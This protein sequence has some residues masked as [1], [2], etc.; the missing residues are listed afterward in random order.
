MA[1]LPTQVREALAAVLRELIDGAGADVGWSLNPRDRGLLASLDALTAAAASA[2]TDGRSSIASHVDHLRYGLELLNRWA[3]GEN[4]PFA[5]AD[6]SASWD[7]QSVSD[8]QWRALRS[9]L[10]R[11]AHAWAIAVAQ[12]HHLDD[13]ELTGMLA[14]AVHLGYHLGAIRQVDAAARGPSAR[15]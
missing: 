1:V 3:G 8:A 4:N 5:D 11:E 15:D 2:R 10:A 14:S 12:P 7:R 13:V 6:Y 9:A